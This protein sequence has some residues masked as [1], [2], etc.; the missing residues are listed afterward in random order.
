[1]FQCQSLDF[2]LESSLLAQRLA[3]EP[4]CLIASQGNMLSEGWA[5]RQADTR[6]CF[7]EEAASEEHP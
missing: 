3:A 4:H 7:Q 2:K 5:Q 1:M 6:G